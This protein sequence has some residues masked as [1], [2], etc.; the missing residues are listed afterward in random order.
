M[1]TPWGC[2]VKKFQCSGYVACIVGLSIK[3]PWTRENS[4]NGLML[5]GSTCP[6]WRPGVL[7][8]LCRGSGR[9][10][11][12]YLVEAH[13]ENE[14]ITTTTTPSVSYS[15]GWPTTGTSLWTQRQNQCVSVFPTGAHLRTCWRTPGWGGVGWRDTRRRR[16]CPPACPWPAWPRPGPS[17]NCSS[18]EWRSSLDT[19]WSEKYDFYS[20]VKLRATILVQFWYFGISVSPYLSRVG[21]KSPFWSKYQY[22]NT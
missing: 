8:W 10:C 7:W 2:W 20:D 5:V 9:G 21:E 12:E 19:L 17:H 6:H 13:K 16:R 18:S 3:L 11:H 1:L 14:K 4:N 22:S 15:Y